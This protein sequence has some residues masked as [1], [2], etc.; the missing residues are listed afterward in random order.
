MDDTW[1]ALTIRRVTGAVTRRRA[2]SCALSPS[3]PVHRPSLHCVW[4]GYDFHAG[5]R[6]R[7]LST[8]L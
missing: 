8:Y 1:F 5:G 7:C 6:S 2:C 3:K 4:C